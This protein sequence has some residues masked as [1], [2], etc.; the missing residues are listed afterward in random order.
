MADDVGKAISRGSG[1]LGDALRVL[2][3]AGINGIGKLPGAKS[4]AAKAFGK[5]QDADRAISSLVAT[6]VSLATAQGV[7]T[8]LGGF[9]AAAVGLPA[10][11]A[12]VS[13]VQIRLVASIAHLRGY[14]VDSARVRTAMVMCLLGRDGVTKMVESG[15]LPSTPLAVA[16]APVHDA[17]L[18]HQISERVFRELLSNLGGRRAAVLV[19]RRIPLLGGGVAGTMDAWATREIAAYAR[20]QFPR[21]RL[22][23]R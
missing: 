18:D 1:E 4:T 7:L 9:L 19:A 22:L 20:E 3:D 10:N 12:A 11:I 16:T 6:H 13:V 14:D 17:T 5:H 21:R 2:L 8:N 23:T 15:Q